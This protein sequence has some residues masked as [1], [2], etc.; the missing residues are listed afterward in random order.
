MNAEQQ[1]SR[2]P[3]PRIRWRY[4]LQFSLRSLLILTTIAGI[5]CWW[6]LQ[7]RSREERLGQ[8]PL[9][10]RRQIR[11]VKIAPASFP[12]R[13]SQVEVVNGQ[14]VAVINSGRWRISRSGGDLLVDGQYANGKE[15]GKWTIYHVNGRKAAEG[16]MVQG[17]KVGWW[18][19]WDEEGR[20][21]SEVE[22][23][24]AIDGDAPRG[25]GG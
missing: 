5:G 13:D 18:R 14:R 15:H 3:G 4:F 22:H 1:S 17:E 19:T 2:V 12:P 24:A 8:T 23:A 25:R 16:M 21:V 7:P 20:L 11:A 10:L 6:F 9:M